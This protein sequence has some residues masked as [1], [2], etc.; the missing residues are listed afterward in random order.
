MLDPL[1]T[2]QRRPLTLPR[3]NFRQKTR[4]RN[5]THPAR[6][7]PDQ[8]F[9]SFRWRW[10]ATRV[11]VDEV[12]SDVILHF[13]SIGRGK[14][15]AA[16]LTSNGRHVRASHT[17]RTTFGYNNLGPCLWRIGPGLRSLHD[18]KRLSH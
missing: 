13:R 18:A 3:D 5:S 15:C 17:F 10:L 12:V 2:T 4:I 7:A 8:P 6:R 16:R 1:M 11:D 14:L 9:L